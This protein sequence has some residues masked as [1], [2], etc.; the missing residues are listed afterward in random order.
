MK[1]KKKSQT[2]ESFPSNLAKFGFSQGEVQQI[3]QTQAFFAAQNESNAYELD[4]IARAVNGEILSDDESDVDPQDFAV[5]TDPLSETAKALVLKRRTAI[6]R[7]ARRLKAK[8]LAQ[9][10]F[11]G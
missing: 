3:S 2:S 5:I 1:P 6:L 9:K 8:A 4:Q 10:R 11:L 7:R